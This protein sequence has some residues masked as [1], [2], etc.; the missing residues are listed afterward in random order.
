M[1]GTKGKTNQNPKS[2]KIEV[3]MSSR[4]NQASEVLDL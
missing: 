1:R 2:H 3:K 4:R